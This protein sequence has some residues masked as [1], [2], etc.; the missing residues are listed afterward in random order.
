MA[1]L[2]SGRELLNAKLEHDLFTMSLAASSVG[3]RKPDRYAMLAEAKAAERKAKAEAYVNY[4]RA[5]M[6]AHS[7]ST[8][9]AKKYRPD[10]LMRQKDGTLD[11]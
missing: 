10:I 5:L 4:R 9:V 7:T 8:Q 6:R 11:E 1:K 2:S 3:K